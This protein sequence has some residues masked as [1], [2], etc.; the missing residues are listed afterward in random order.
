M[1]KLWFF[2]VGRIYR[3][4]QSFAANG[5]KQVENPAYSLRKGQKTRSGSAAEKCVFR[6][7][8]RKIDAAAAGESGIFI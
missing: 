7:F 6:T 2:M 1:G 8:L 3:K 4:V 5:G